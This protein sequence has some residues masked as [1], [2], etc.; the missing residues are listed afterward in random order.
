[1]KR[2]SGWPIGVVVI[3]AATVGLNLWVYRVANDDP[4]FAIEPNYYQKAVDWDSTMAQERRNLALGWRVSPTL[5]AFSARDGARLQVT[6]TDASGAAIRGATVKVAAFFNARAND[7]VDTT[8]VSDSTGYG[9]R[10]PVTRG[11]VWELRFDVTR[12]RERFTSTSRVEAVQADH[13][14]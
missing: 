1:M 10:L 13:G 4:S 9:G 14:I 7:V 8:L 12:G 5:A 6:L 11:G 2:G 3:L